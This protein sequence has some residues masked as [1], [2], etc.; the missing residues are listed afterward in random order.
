MEK[1]RR[2][3]YEAFLTPPESQLAI[4]HGQIRIGATD[5]EATGGSSPHAR[6]AAAIF[7]L[8]GIGQIHL[9]GIVRG[10]CLFDHW[11]AAF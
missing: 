4:M 6:Q 2:L 10:R 9:A 3:G 7:D 1:R 8:R 5:A 11:R